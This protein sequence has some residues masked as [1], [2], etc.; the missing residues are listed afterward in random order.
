MDER[1][2]AWLR[3]GRATLPESIKRVVLQHFPDPLEALSAD[4]SVLPRQNRLH[5]LGQG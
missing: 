3:I 5:V 4:L 2:L 1:N